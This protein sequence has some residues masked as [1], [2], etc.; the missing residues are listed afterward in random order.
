MFGHPSGRP[1]NVRP[2]G[3]LPSN[4]VCSGPTKNT[5]FH[6]CQLRLHARCS[7]PTDPDIAER[8]ETRIVQ[9]WL[10]LDD[11]LPRSG[12]PRMRRLSLMSTLLLAM[13]GHPSRRPVNVRPDGRLLSHPVRPGPTK[14][15]C[16]ANA[17]QS[18]RHVRR[19]LSAA[20]GDPSPEVR[21]TAYQ[22]LNLYDFLP[23][24]PFLLTRPSGM[25]G[26]LRNPLWTNHFR[27]HR[28]RCPPNG[29]RQL[30]LDR[31]GVRW[32]DPP[33]PP[34]ARYRVEFGVPFVPSCG[35]PIRCASPAG[36]HGSGGASAPPAIRPPGSSVRRRKPRNPS[37]G[38]PG[39][40]IVAAGS[41]GWR[42]RR[43]RGC[44][45]VSRRTPERCRVV[46]RTLPVALGDAGS[47]GDG[48]SRRP[49]ARGG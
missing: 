16:P 45:G 21:H 6:A 14:N 41:P 43:R 25:S 2:D 29:V 22:S 13:F 8:Q 32:P 15:P 44:P 49:C 18:M 1:V 7:G 26:T 10:D 31:G 17:R 33:G 40:V 28:V 37:P 19:F 48:R 23:R 24:F 3:R 36:P 47:R 9:S 30:M 42:D 39:P 12:P 38:C 11:S 46:A 5:R 27:R 34:P 35:R 20:S 4:P